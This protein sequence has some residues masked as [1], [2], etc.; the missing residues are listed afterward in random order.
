MEQI[1]HIKCLIEEV[2]TGTQRSPATI[3]RLASGGDG[4]MYARLVAGHDITTRRAERILRWLSSHWPADLPWPDGIARPASDEDAAPAT[5]DEVLAQVEEA[6]AARSHARWRQNDMV[7]AAGHERRAITAA[8][9]LG[10]DGQ[11]LAPA[12]LARVLGVDI[13]VYRDV[14]HRYRDGGAMP[15]SWPRRGSQAD[16]M[17]AALAASGDARFRGRVQGLALRRAVGRAA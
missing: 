12:A 8:L 3:G 14:C 5:P 13:Q 2:A 16:E 4:R 9:T 10:A 6:L 11:L 7:A 15:G 1:S 17:L